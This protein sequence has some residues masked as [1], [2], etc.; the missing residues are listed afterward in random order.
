M[1]PRN[2]YEADRSPEAFRWVSGR[3]LEWIRLNHVSTFDTQST[4]KKVQQMYPNYL[5]SDIGHM[6]FVYDYKY[7]GE[8]RVRLV[9]DGSKQSPATYSMTYAPT[10]RAESVRL[11]HIYAVEYSWAIQQYDVPQAFLRSDA[12]CD[13]F[14]YPPMVL[15]SFRDNCSS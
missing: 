10:V 13:I 1:I 11:F 2:D 12:D 14:A 6:F 9:F 15:L 8:H 5:K 3:T 7:S 4:W